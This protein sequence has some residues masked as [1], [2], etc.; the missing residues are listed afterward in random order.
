MAPVSAHIRERTHTQ[1]VFAH[2]LQFN[3]F[4]HTILILIRLGIDFF[5]SC[6]LQRRRGRLRSKQI[7]NRIEVNGYETDEMRLNWLNE[8]NVIRTSIGSLV[9][10]HS[11][12][13]AA[14][15]GSQSLAYDAMTNGLPVNI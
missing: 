8:L 6:I 12:N 7:F 13:R 2:W 9:L 4:A 14:S 15:T 1:I 3:R 11:W 10:V 5:F